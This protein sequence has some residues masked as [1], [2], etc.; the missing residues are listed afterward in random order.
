M[1]YFPYNYSTKGNKILCLINPI[2][3][4]FYNKLLTKKKYNFDFL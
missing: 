1:K 2:I 4:Q 3:C